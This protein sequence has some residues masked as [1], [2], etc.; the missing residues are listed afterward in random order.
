MKSLCQRERNSGGTMQ[1][2]DPSGCAVCG[3]S[4]AGIVASSPAGSMDVFLCECFVLYKYRPLWRADPSSRGV[5]QN[6]IW[7]NN[8]PLHLQW[9][10]TRGRTKRKH[11][12]P[13]INIVLR[14]TRS[15]KRNINLDSTQFHRHTGQNRIRPPSCFEHPHKIPAQVINLLKQWD[16]VWWSNYA[17]IY[18]H[19]LGAY[20]LNILLLK[21]CMLSSYSKRHYCANKTPH[22]VT[23]YLFVSTTPHHYTVINEESFF[24][25]PLLCLHIFRLKYL[26]IL[27]LP[28][29]CYISTHIVLIFLIS[30]IMC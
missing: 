26:V 5:L 18:Y 30:L 29:A 16:G 9:V 10:R 24:P 8:I 4:L 11:Y 6:A 27:T 21:N 1:G 14:Y 25:L 28:Q 7:Y 12:K 3:R 23:S 2:T 17:L 19:C 15:I 22:S 20:V 13:H